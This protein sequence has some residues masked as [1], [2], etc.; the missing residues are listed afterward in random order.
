MLQNLY[1]LYSSLLGLETQWSCFACKA[2]PAVKRMNLLLLQGT[3]SQ[4]SVIFEQ[5]LANCL[6][7]K[8]YQPAK[9]SSNNI[10]GLKHVYKQNYARLNKKRIED[11]ITALTSYAS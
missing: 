6:Y 1:E 11:Y 4:D 7:V 2:R 10:C 8:L 5:S 9:S 3:L